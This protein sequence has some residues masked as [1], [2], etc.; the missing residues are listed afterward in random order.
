MVNEGAIMG[1]VYDFDTIINRKNTNSVKWDYM[2]AK[3][4]RDDLIHLGVAD[5]DFKS[6]RPVLDAMQKVIDYGIF[7]YIGINDSFYT[8][9]QGW[10]KKKT[11][12]SIPRD[13]IVY[14]PKVNMASS[15]CVEALTGPE[16]K[17]IINSPIYNPLREA[18]TK[19]NRRPVE[20]PLIIKNGKFTMN[21]DYLESAAD[22]ETE[23]FIL[24]NPDN[25]STR[26]WS[27]EEMER[28]ADFCIRN[29]LILFADE[30]HSD[31][32]A[33]GV[34]FFSSLNLNQKI[35]DRLVYAS[36]LTKTFN[37]PGIIISYMI[38]P[39][40]ELRNKIKNAIDRVGL[41]SPN[42]F[43]LAAIEAAYN[44]CDDWLKAVNE[45]INGNEKL[46]RNFIEEHMKELKVMPR[47][48]TYL[49]WVDY[50]ELG[51]DED[52]LCKWFINDAKVEV[53]MGSAFGK[54]GR[55]YFRVNIA[56]SRRLLNEALNNME[57][58][59]Y[60]IKR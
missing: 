25:P 38:I 14:C 47:E 19:N 50:S 31:I 30:I 17:V 27:K 16:A 2:A 32:I 24:C 23:M 33:E 12:I 35:Y 5:M 57:N 18:I 3:Y 59:Y 43:S 44:Y 39:N 8:S 52:E 4:G 58:A 22:N 1:S 37:I 15:I 53:Q 60:K 7:G 42:I 34:Q 45:Y 28:L 9:I 41:N 49:L 36:S 40:K 6:P 46:F 48:G 20:S 56:T 55:G 26:A 13:W 11:G 54:E 51:I 10:I 21:F 29:N